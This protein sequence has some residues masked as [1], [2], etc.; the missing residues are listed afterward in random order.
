M[1]RW[2][3]VRLLALIIG[4]LGVSM[5]IGGVQLALLGGSVYY[6]L[7]G[8]GLMVSA[9]LQWLEHRWGAWSYAAVLV[10]TLVWSVFEAGF[11]AWGLAARLGLLAV[12]GLGVLAVNA[13]T[14][15]PYVG[16]ALVASALLGVTALRSG[17]RSTAGIAARA[18]TATNVP[19]EWSVY[20]GN[21]RGTRFAPHTQITP[22]NVADLEQAWVYTSGDLAAGGDEPIDALGGLRGLYGISGLQA[23]PVQ[24]GNR[25][26][27]CTERGMA[28]ALD[29]ES[30]RE[31]W[32]FDPQAHPRVLTHS[33]CRGVAYYRAP[34]ASGHCAARI[35]F[36]SL[37]S[38]LWAIDAGS[39]APCTDFGNA[40]SVSLREG[41]NSPEIGYHM[42][43]PG[44]IADG[45][46]VVGAWIPDNQLVV[47]PS[48]V[49]RGYDVIT[50]KLAWA[51]DMGRPDRAQ[52]PPEGETYTPGTPNVW[53]FGSADEALGLVFVPLGNPSPDLWGGNRREFDERYS[54]SVVAL[55]VRTGRPRWSFQTVHHDIW[56][57]DIPAQPVLFDIPFPQGARP[58]VIQPTK[59]GDIFVLDR[60]S[61][62]PI[63]PVEE[64][65]VAQGAV[66]GDRVSPTQPFS[67]LSVRPADL[68]EQQMWG[69]T[70]LDQLWCRLQFRR[71]RYE[72]P[73]TPPG[74]QPTINHPGS[75]G[76]V[77]WG[78]VTVDESRSILVTNKTSVAYYMQLIP[79]EVA[80]E[81]ARKRRD[82][83]SYQWLPMEQTPY[84]AR[85]RPFVSP[86]KIPCNEP[87]WGHVEAFDL[88]SAKSLWKRPLGTARDSGPFGWPTHVPLPIGT[89]MQGG[90]ITTASGLTFIA[91][92]TDN[93]LRALDTQTGKELWRGRLPAG[94]QATPMTYVSPDSGRQ[95]VVIAAGGHAGM[96]TRRGDYVV[97]FALPPRRGQG[98]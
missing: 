23:T 33:S 5:T 19:G 7:A 25:L 11:G 12:L 75:F 42:T 51:W 38:K 94:G 3:V 54:S 35:L 79:R 86:L 26:Y 71:A 14:W 70:P 31:L 29:A 64:R 83:T 78:G 47:A 68:S 17:E 67:A 62:E 39:G 13:R 53:S 65:A 28:I 80:P 81:S 69:M 60:R 2:W 34:Q 85:I 55:D 48:G 97:A 10:L 58:A 8:V 88:V 18:A 73:Y 63:V 15:L 49:V 43:S 56:D 61:G 44:T 40:G 59:P 16:I 32:R 76:S 90:A 87:P 1:K 20:G 24:V 41:L 46:I 4:A 27:S 45:V 50:G 92:T 22:E 21:A 57:Y 30:G 91:A 6:A 93:Y 84:V 95:F 77:S 36:G 66:P 37:D 96:R 74:E 72:G 98:M 9:V 89:P 82:P 52:A